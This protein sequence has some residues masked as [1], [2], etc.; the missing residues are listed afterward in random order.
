MHTPENIELFGALTIEGFGEAYNIGRT[1]VY[2]EIKT[3][4]L[5]AVKVRK[6]TLI[7]R[8]DADAWARSLLEMRI[9][10]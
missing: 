5:R 3:G 2:E 1:T 9:G 8:R 10:S 6:R 4:R 7:L